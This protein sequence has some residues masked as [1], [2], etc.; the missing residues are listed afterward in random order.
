MTTTLEP[1]AQSSSRE[2]PLGESERLIGRTDDGFVCNLLPSKGTQTDFRLQDAVESGLLS[3]TAPPPALDLRASWWPVGNQEQTG[4]CV[5]WASADG[6]GRYLMVTAGRIEEQVRLAPRY[7]WMAS[8]ELD[9][10]GRR[11]TTF[12]ELSGTSLKAAAAV[13][14]NY[15]FALESELPFH[16]QTTMFAGSENSLFASCSRRRVTYVNLQLRLDHWKIWLN[17]NGPILVGLKVDS[18]WSKCRGETLDEFDSGS[19]FGGH[20]VCIVGYREDG[21][22]IVRNS[23]GNMWGDEGFAY[24]T[25]AYIHAAFFNES[26]G[27]TLA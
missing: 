21:T 25:A 7:I 2:D 11:P 23:W 15:G 16:I 1:Q 12:V 19:I 6:V 24:L 3:A 8:K 27:F 5:G 22:F 18:N 14:H 20:A 4:S 13:A 10:D 9:E 17:E 26:Y